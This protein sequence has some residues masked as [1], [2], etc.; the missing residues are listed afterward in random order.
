MTRFQ[1]AVNVM[2]GNDGWKEV[3]VYEVRRRLLHK[4]LERRLPF[5]EPRDWNLAPTTSRGAHPR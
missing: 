1:W 2:I 4:R 3:K 5:L